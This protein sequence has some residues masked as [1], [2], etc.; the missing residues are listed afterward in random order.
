LLVV[1]GKPAHDNTLRWLYGAIKTRWQGPFTIDTAVRCHEPKG[2]KP[3]EVAGAVAACR[4]YAAGTHAQG[5]DRIILSGSGACTVWLGRRADTY[6]AR[7]GWAWVGGTPAFLVPDIIAARGNSVETD[8]F[9]AALTT[10]CRATRPAAPQ[11]PTPMVV[12]TPAEAEQ[13]YAAVRAAGGYA[14]DVESY[15][16]PFNDD[17]R[18]TTL[19]LQPDTAGHPW[20]YV[21]ET[22]GG[23]IG[24][25]LRRLLVDR[26]LRVTAQN[27]KYD[28]VAVRAYLGV[29]Q[30]PHYADTRLLRR[31]E[32][33]EAGASLSAQADM[34][35]L[36]GL[37]DA[38]GAAVDVAKRAFNKS[39]KA[40]NVR[41]DMPAAELYVARRLREPAAYAYGEVAQ[42]LLSAYCAADVHTT[43]EVARHQ[44]R[45]PRG[46]DAWRAWE[47]VGR[48]ANYALTQM[49]AVGVG[50]DRGVA[51]SVR[52]WARSETAALTTALQLAG[53]NNPASV[54]Q[55][56][57]YLFKQL[58][59]RPTKLTAKRAPSTDAAS[60]VALRGQHP[61]IET[62]LAWRRM[63]TLRKTFAEP[64]PTI[65][66]DDGRVHTSYNQDGARTGRISSSDP[67]LQNII[68]G[69]SE[70]GR[71][72]RQAFVPR[73]GYV[74]VQL[75][76]SQ[77]EIRIAADISGDEAMLG[78]YHRGEDY[79]A[80]T[81]RLVSPTV[82]GDD[83]DTLDADRKKERRTAAKVVVFSLFYGKGDEGL[84]EDL[85]ITV[86]TAAKLRAAVLG[87]FRGY[88]AW[89]DATLRKAQ[90]EG[91]VHTYWRG[92]P[93]RWRPLP[94][95][96]SG[97]SG[98]RG[99][100][101]RAAINTPIQ[102]TGSDFCLAALGQ[103][104][105]AF[106]ADEVPANVV[107]TVHDSIVLE[108]DERYWREAAGIAKRIM[109][110]QPT[111]NGVPLVADVEVG[112]TWADMEKVDIGA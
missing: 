11:Y 64:L 97:S 89:Q 48:A 82:W 41:A 77:L 63:D 30:G 71:R 43:N 104:V 3:G 98:L 58:R 102:G 83:Y 20:V 7:G 8:T 76:Y 39:L 21:W 26:Q 93:F 29:V 31:L 47:E 35:G 81:A 4:T 49:E 14:Y 34:V 88:A 60:L 66:R 45:L 112:P 110:T 85:G 87:S 38:V 84:A 79:H 22:F 5:Y 44:R 86:P 52:E 70:E 90:A 92:Q 16:L 17:F 105:P 9:L 2:A 12:T 25:T 108:A 55:L 62:L 18:L 69:T 72:I 59:L 23:T 56:S 75:D 1:L 61:V 32:D 99:N 103:I 107:L 36:G 28:A 91:G 50:V 94:H 10:A 96:G 46:A 40:G 109:E 27:G 100:A 54:P 15:G 74:L 95:L 78:I 101:E 19:A 51:L 37:K 42:P 24:A 33:A 13:A 68:R 65:I 106:E 57:D 80:A 67:N 53:L 6:S 111:M 73:R